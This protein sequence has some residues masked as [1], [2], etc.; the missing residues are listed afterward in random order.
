MACISSIGIYDS[1]S[2][3]IT[4]NPKGNSDFEVLILQENARSKSSRKERNIEIVGNVAEKRTLRKIEESRNR[5][6]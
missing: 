5:T 3:T 1:V 2:W 4:K 6:I